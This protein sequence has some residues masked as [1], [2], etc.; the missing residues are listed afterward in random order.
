MFCFTYGSRV[1]ENE[2]KV[3]L[4]KYARWV[5]NLLHA[6][7]TVFV[8]LFLFILFNFLLPILA[9]NVDLTFVKML[10]LVRDGAE[11]MLG[12][13]VLSAF[14]VASQQSFCWILAVAFTC[15]YQFGAVCIIAALGNFESE[16]EK[17][18]ESYRDDSE[19]AQAEL[20]CSTVSYKY[21]VCFLS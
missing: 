13:S 21:K 9:R 20:V 19:E 1:V 4:Q 3:K 7:V 14:S 17:E 5:G 10:Y 12:H 2:R 6:I 18:R 15:A 16:T 8:T 11:V